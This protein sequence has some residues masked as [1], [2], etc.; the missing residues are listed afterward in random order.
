M[1]EC[2]FESCLK[3]V[4]V[5]SSGLCGA[6]YQAARKDGT[7]TPAFRWVD[8]YGVR[9]SCSQLECERGVKARGLCSMHYGRAVAG[10]KPK[11]GFRE[12]KWVAPDGTR[13]TCMA[14][15]CPNAVQAKG[16]CAAHY[17]RMTRHASLDLPVPRMDLCPTPHCDREKSPRADLC[18]ECRKIRWRYGLSLE[19]TMY[20]MTPENRCCSNGG[21]KSAKD[22]HLDHDH[23]CCPPGSFSASTRVSC[24]GCVRGWLCR[25]CNVSLG[26][27]QE[28]PRRIEGL[29]VYLR[30]FKP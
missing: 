20:L 7:L 14:P 5:K 23:S 29:L 19:R 9:R 18:A 12:T 8:E 30:G 4:K 27:M 13:I 2:S 3:P 11:K 28:D 1:S 25:G 17:T 24:G 6:H 26:F 10:R 21:C 15:D 16:L 22:L